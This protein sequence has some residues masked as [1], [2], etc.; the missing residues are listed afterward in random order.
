MSMFLDYDILAI[1][2]TALHSVV[3]YI[4]DGPLESRVLPLLPP[5]LAATNG[6][7]EANTIAHGF[8][9]A[10]SFQAICCRDTVTLD[11]VLFLTRNPK[12]KQYRKTFKN[13]NYLENRVA[14]TTITVT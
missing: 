14:F 9:S 12:T 7:Q 8:C 3:V 4:H 11:V 10:C 2:V 6:K 1:I 5:R 13:D